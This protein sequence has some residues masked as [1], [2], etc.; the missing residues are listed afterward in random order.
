[1]KACVDIGGT[2]VAVS[3]AYA[4]T[5]G[6]RALPTDALRHRRVE[7]TATTGTPDAVALQ[8]LRMLGQACDDAGARL[9]DIEAV[10]VSSCGPFV[11]K[12]GMN[13]DQRPECAVTKVSTIHW[14][15]T[16][17]F[18]PTGNARNWALA[19][20]GHTITNHRRW[21][22]TASRPCAIQSLLLD[23]MTGR[24]LPHSLP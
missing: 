20:Y 10:G 15:I 1:M 22:R 9:T 17:L 4:A 2:K 12:A 19:G 18:E 7:A 21:H 13:P 6:A 3:L 24:G 5:E 23:P 16:R 14:R 8:I 11:L